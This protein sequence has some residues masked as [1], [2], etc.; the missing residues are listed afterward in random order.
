MRTTICLNDELLTDAKHY[1]LGRK[2]TL[3]IVIEEVLREKLR[4]SQSR[5]TKAKKKVS[6]PSDGTGGVLPGIDINNN[7]ELLDVM[8]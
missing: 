2:T 3:T 1:A 5:S 4:K 7:A 8:E 6:L